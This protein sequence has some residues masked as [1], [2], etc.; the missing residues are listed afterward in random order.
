MT[1]TLECGMPRTRL[2]SYAHSTPEDPIPGYEHVENHVSRCAVCQ[3]VLAE[4]AD[5]AELTKQLREETQN[6][7]R[8]DNW[9]KNLIENI[10]LPFREGK[11]IEV[12]SETGNNLAVSEMLVRRLV[13]S[14]CSN[15]DIW[16]LKTEV[17]EDSDPDAPESLD[18]DV[19]VRYGR[20]IPDLVDD[21]R[22]RVADVWQTQTGRAVGAVNVAVLDVFG[23]ELNDQ[24]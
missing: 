16:V 5:I 6:A 22:K 1:K 2:M 3:N 4:Q 7:P 9:A 19:A 24:S 20:R 17:N 14:S 15:P 21:L 8:D 10:T 18:V 11:P 12:E 23:E 13:R